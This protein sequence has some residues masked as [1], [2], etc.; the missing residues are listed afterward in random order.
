MALT[1]IT[2]GVAAAGQA[3]SWQE[4]HDLLVKRL[5]NLQ[6]KAG[7][8]GESYRPIYQAALPWYERWGGIN[9]DPVD[10]WMVSPEKYADD[11]A[12]AL[13]KG[14]NFVAENPGA[15]IPL[16]FE[17]TLP[18][19]EKISVKYWLKLPAGF[20]SRSAHFPLIIGL[21]GS[22]WLGHKISFVR[23]GG[24]SGPCFEVTP[25]NEGG[26][27]RID[28]LNVFL[29]RLLATLP[30]DA[31][32]VYVEGHSLGGIATWEW[33]TKNPERLAAISPRAGAWYPFEAS[34]L[35]QVPSWVIHGEND[36]VILRGFAEQ[37]V[38]ALQNCGASTRLTVLRGAMHNLPDDF[39]NQPV[40]DWYLRQTRS[41]APPPPDP[42]GALGLNADGFSRWEFISIPAQ[43]GWKTGP[44]KFHGVT[45]ANFETGYRMAVE[46]LFAQVHRLGESVDAPVRFEADLNTGESTA[47]LVAPNRLSK[48]AYSEPSLVMLPARHVV[49]FYCRGLPTKAFAHVHEL[50]REIVASGHTIA[51]DHVWITGL[52]GPS[53]TPDFLAEYW[54]DIN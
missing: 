10:S 30:I 28:F 34:R 19:G 7:E 46:P 40:V 3:D 35:K 12:D 38:S 47:W 31:D 36:N 26:S 9:R 6:D 37:M 54:I 52:V 5:R 22:G 29:D 13:E 45:A 23:G 24:G 33:A 14:M 49:R 8:F 48:S 27:W 42:A 21:H 2:A 20:P 41:H 17:T 15:Q 44:H 39:D 51:N 16:V 50:V 4:Q 32:R 11:L 25:I 43:Q 53:D 18:G 1:G